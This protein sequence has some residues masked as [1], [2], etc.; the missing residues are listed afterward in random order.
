MNDFMEKKEILRQLSKEELIDLVEIA[1]NDFWGCQGNWIY[2]IENEHGLEEAA[3]ADEKI[4]PRIAKAQA[5]EVKELFDLG[6]DIQSLKRSLELC[7]YSGGFLEA[8][9]LEVTD[10]RLKIQ[11]NKCGQDIRLEQ[12]REVLPCKPAG[13][14]CF[15]SHANVINPNI[16]VNCV[17]CPP[18]E[19]PDDAWCEWEF[20]LEE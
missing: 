3:K 15:K 7:T 2:Y 5:Q 9:F 20:E 1:G 11:I 13:L 19:H 14:G 6:D 16:N 8:Q 18:D 12:G 10:N 4:F 17:F